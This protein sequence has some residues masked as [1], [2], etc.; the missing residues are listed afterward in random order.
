MYMLLLVTLL[1]LLFTLML[2]LKLIFC[3]SVGSKSSNLVA[4][5]VSPDHLSALGATFVQETGKLL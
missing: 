2:V 5:S 1:V 4:S 3:H